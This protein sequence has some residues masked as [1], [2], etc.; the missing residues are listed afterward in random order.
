MA[1]HVSAMNPVLQ[2]N[3]CF[4]LSQCNQVFISALQSTISHKETK[5]KFS[6]EKED[7]SGCCAR[8]QFTL[9]HVETVLGTLIARC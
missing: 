4:W 1:V 8:E 5:S 7:I 2:Q 3:G 6:A 9:F